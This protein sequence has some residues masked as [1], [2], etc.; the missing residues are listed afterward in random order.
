MNKLI[1]KF[2][3]EFSIKT[4]GQ[5]T[6]IISN[7]SNRFESIKIALRTEH[8]TNKERATIQVLCFEYADILHLEDCMYRC[9]I[10]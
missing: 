1:Y 8:M 10:S 6:Q 9:N 4:I 3:N 5:S 7:S 2:I